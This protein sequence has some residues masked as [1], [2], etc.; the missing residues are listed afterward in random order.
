MACGNISTLPT[1]S[2]WLCEMATYLMSAGFTPS[3]SSC[4]ASVLVTCQWIARGSDGASPFGMAA[5]ESGVPQQ[6]ALSVMDQITVF[7]HLHRLADI[8][9]RPA[10]NVAGDAVATI[11]DIEFVDARFGLRRS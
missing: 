2:G 4:E 9:P 11:E 7:R 5:I 1:W 3:V 6:P 8:E 10:R